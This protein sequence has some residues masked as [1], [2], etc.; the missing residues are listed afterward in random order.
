MTRQLLTITTAICFLFIACNIPTM[1]DTQT[2]PIVSTATEKIL[3]RPTYQ[4][5]YYS[6]WTIDSSDTDFDLDSYFI[7]NTA[8][9]NGSTTFFIYN[10][11]IDEQQ[12][13]DAQVKAHLDNVIKNGTVRTLTL[14]EN[15]KD[16]VRQ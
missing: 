3:D 10:T 1:T 12:H 15:I 9:N 11:T 7:L 5:K 13:L 16:T 6:D 14:G 8:S 4:R 2:V